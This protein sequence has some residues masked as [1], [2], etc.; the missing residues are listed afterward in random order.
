MKFFEKGAEA[1]VRK[2]VCLRSVV[3]PG[4]WEPVLYK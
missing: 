2:M 3:L 4:W 1:H